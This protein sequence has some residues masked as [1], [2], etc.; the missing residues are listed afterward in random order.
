MLRCL[1]IVK[2]WLYLTLRG[3]LRRGGATIGHIC[4]PAYATVKAVC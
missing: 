2:A 1:D 3:M 4:P